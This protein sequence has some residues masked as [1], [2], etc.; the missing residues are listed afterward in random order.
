MA[1]LSQPDIKNIGGLASPR[2][3]RRPAVIL[4][5]LVI[6]AL[7]AAA[8]YLW[9]RASV[10]GRVAHPSADRIITIEPGMSPQSII[11]RLSEAG[12]VSNPTALKIYLRLSG[13]ASQLKAGD[14]KFDSPTSPL[15]AIEKIRRGEV[16]L[17]R[18]TIPEGFNRFDI[19]ETLATRTGKAT[20]E[21]FL[22]LMEDQTPILQFAPQA[23]DLEGY[24]FPDT[25]TYTSKTTPEELIRAMVTRFNE[26]FT[27]EWRARATE[28]GMNI[29]QVVTLASIIEEE[30][31]VADERPLISSVFK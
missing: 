22:R 24:L 29:H 10:T 19:A 3:R 20:R 25:Y 30:A 11:A 13:S 17:E 6:A 18:V 21:E 7:V 12:I 31:R 1:D 8:A 9:L 14:Y 2:R 4:L 27:P 28:L 26:V 23:R 15:E 5:L 16:Y